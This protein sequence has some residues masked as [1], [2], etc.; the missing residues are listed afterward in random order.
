M[1]KQLTTALT[2]ASATL[3]ALPAHAQGAIDGP[4]HWRYDWDWGFGHMMFGGL[5][6]LLFW[7]G[8]ILVIVLVVRWLSGSSSPELRPP[9]R[10]T[11]REILDEHFARGEIDKQEFKE[12]KRILSE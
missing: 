3:F 9:T 7:G 10:K 12:R 11:P 6:M 4:D 8:L 2:A 1:G 5:M